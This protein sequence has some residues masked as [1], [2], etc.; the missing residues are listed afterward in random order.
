MNKKTFQRRLQS[1]LEQVN[2]PS[3]TEELLNIMEQQVLDDTEKVQ[4][5]QLT[6]L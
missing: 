4:M 1:L 5:L 2:K 3:H 6:L